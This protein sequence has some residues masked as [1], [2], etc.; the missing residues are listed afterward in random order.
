MDRRSRSEIVVNKVDGSNIDLKINLE[1]EAS[2]K[3]AA[4]IDRL[5]AAI[6]KLSG[7]KIDLPISLLNQHF[8]AQQQAFQEEVQRSAPPKPELTKR[9]FELRE[10]EIIPD[11]IFK[12]SEV[13]SFGD[14]IKPQ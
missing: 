14:D 1:S 11:D 5:A 3:L 12:S 2:E 9:D 13:I 8:P 10:A 4:A 7:I 6:E